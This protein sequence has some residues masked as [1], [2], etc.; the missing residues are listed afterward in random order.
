MLQS[1]AFSHLAKSPVEFIGNRH[2]SVMTSRASDAYIE[3][4]F[5]LFNIKRYQHFYHIKRFFDEILCD[6]MLQNI[7][8]HL[9]IV[10][11]KRS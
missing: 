11:R 8:A 3:T 2:R 6:L 9:G 5:S 1:C 4:V 10:S 7:S